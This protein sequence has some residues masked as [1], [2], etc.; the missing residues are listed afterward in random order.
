MSDHL[1]KSKISRRAVF[2]TTGKAVASVALTPVIQSAIVSCIASSDAAA[3]EQAPLN[4]IAGI[5]RVTVL[6]GKTYL[7]G[8]AGYGNPP[9]TVRGRGAA[10]GSNQPPPVPSGPAP[11]V[12]WSKES[13]P[14]T[15]AFA[16]SKSLITTATF[17]TPG[18]YVLKLTADN[19]RTTASSTLN[20]LVETPPPAKQ[21]DAVYTKNFKIDNPLWSAKSK[22]LMVNWIPHCIDQINRTDLTL[23]SEERRVGK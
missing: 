4:G 15:V 19:G 21:L 9:S 22:A 3:E 23:R 2:Q 18:V 8:W 10:P 16:D 1:T 11:T 14:G 12:T 20:V 17:S 7:R 5:D 13:G 6:Q